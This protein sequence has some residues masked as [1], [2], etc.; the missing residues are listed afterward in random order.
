MMFG[1]TFLTHHRQKR[2]KEESCGLLQQLN[3]FSAGETSHGRPRR[4]ALPKRRNQLLSRSKNITVE[5][6][7]WEK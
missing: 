4:G 6:E 1:A 7:D 2:A 5:L 3:D